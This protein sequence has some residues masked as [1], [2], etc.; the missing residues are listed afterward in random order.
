[1]LGERIVESVV[2]FEETDA[3]YFEWADGRCWLP[4]AEMFSRWC[5]HARLSR[6]EERT[7]QP[8]FDSWRD[9]M[10]AALHRGIRAGVLELNDFGR[11]ELHHDIEH[12]LWA[13]QDEY[14]ADEFEATLKLQE[15]LESQQW[16]VVCDD[17]LPQDYLRSKV[18][19]ARRTLVCPRV[20]AIG[21][22]GGTL[23]ICAIFL[24][25]PI[26]YVLAVVA[27]ANFALVGYVIRKRSREPEF[28]EYTI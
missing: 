15:F 28:Y 11:P 4:P 6:L 25:A 8:K 19:I 1:M 24:P 18:G 20:L 2:Q 14:P 23:L 27:L 12:R 13:L 26:R 7:D 21:A 3:F 16:P 10:H 17:V 22:I 9:S 5:V